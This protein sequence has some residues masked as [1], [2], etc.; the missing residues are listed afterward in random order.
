M[1]FVIRLAIFSFI[2]AAV[3]TIIDVGTDGLLVNEYNDRFLNASETGE[4]NWNNPD[5]FYIRRH[6]EPELYLVF[7]YLTMG[8]ILSGGCVQFAVVIYLFVRADPNLQ[9]L[10]K[11]LRVLLLLTALILMAPVLVNF[12]AAFYVFRNAEDDNIKSH[13]AT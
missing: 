5:I 4:P 12:Y 11:P 2:A 8:C 13:I 9:L 10:P 7:K 6:A 3:F 1:E